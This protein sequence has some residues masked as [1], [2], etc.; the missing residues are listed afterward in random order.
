MSE[1]FIGIT[2]IAFGTSL[3]EFIVSISS[4][5]KGEQDIL[6]GNIIGSNNANIGLVLALTALVYPIK[7]NF[8]IIKKE[9]LIEKFLSLFASKINTSKFLNLQGL[10]SIW[11]PNI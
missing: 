7:V 8:Q 5:I 11:I 6:I 1:K 10:I 2:L 9:K 4:N 3:P